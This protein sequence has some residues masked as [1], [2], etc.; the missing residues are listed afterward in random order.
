MN[1]PVNRDDLR[2]A[3]VDSLSAPSEDIARHVLAMAGANPNQIE[4]AITTG[5]GLV[6]YDL[7]APA[8]N[9]F[10]S[11]F[12][13]TFL[14]G[15]RWLLLAW[16]LSPLALV[17]VQLVVGPY[18]GLGPD[19]AGFLF[20]PIDLLFG[21]GVV[22]GLIYVRYRSAWKPSAWAGPATLVGC[23]AVFAIAV[24][25]QYT[26]AITWQVA[27]VGVVSCVCLAVACATPAPRGFIG[28]LGR[29]F[30]DAS[31]CIYLT[32]V[33]FV[34]AALGFLSHHARGLPEG[35]VIVITFFFAA[36]SG[37]ALH[38]LAERPIVAWSQRLIFPKRI[39][40]R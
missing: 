10:Y 9:L 21:M 31:Y 14:S 11:V 3:V 29:R 4:K 5:T 26:R 33:A 23:A 19:L 39:E 22:L 16:V 18:V 17:A 1:A 32:H 6:A 7:Q 38:Y 34:S 2:K 20:N 40:G 28:D 27:V 37:L 36:V 25:F 15:R 12:A 35:G 8:K 13:L 24:A 30:G